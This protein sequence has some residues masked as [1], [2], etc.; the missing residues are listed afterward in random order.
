MPVQAAAAAAAAAAT[1][2][3]I[4]MA[5]PPT[6]APAGRMYVPIP[7]RRSNRDTHPSYHYTYMKGGRRLT[8]RQ[9]PPLPGRRRGRY[10]TYGGNSLT[11][12]S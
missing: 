11:T 10:T 4:W 9:P 3:L 2:A 6:P 7:P 1:Q 12:W 8:W 5:A